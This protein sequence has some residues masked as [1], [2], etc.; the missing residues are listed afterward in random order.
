MKTTNK[1]IFYKIFETI[2]IFLIIYILSLISYYVLSGYIKLML[3]YKDS[4]ENIIFLS[5]IYLLFFYG[6][7]RIFI[8]LDYRLWL[9]I[10]DLRT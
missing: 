2:I 6:I 4:L 1:Y 10:K 9:G 7:I 5:L 3:I 8:Y